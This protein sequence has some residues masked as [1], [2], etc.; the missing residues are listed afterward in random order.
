MPRRKLFDSSSTAPFK[1][2]RSKID[3]AIS[4]PRCFVL[5]VRE[6]VKRPDG[7]PF[8]LNIAVDTLLK[9]EFDLYRASQTPHPL[10]AAAG[11]DVV[12]F[13]HPKLG[14][15][16]NNFKGLDV[17]HAQTNLEIFGS[18]D[19]IWT[20]P[21]GTLH[22]VDYKAT[23]KGDDLAPRL[24]NVAQHHAAYKRQAEIY[25]WLL[26]RCQDQPVSKTAYFVY[27]NG[28]PSKPRFDERLEFR[29]TLIPYEGSHDW[30]EPALERIAETL[31][32]PILPPPA[33]DCDYCA[34]RA[35]LRPIEE[36]LG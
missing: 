12:P 2:S 35:A 23:A 14:D 30:I 5:D 33:Q 20:Q 26:A 1:I 21:D 8:T 36:D 32:T 31:R 13:N 16:R 3:L 11:L 17:V 15:W 6:G 28:I 18:V 4:C 9:R 10:T 25:Q 19:D 34:Y 27:V 7:Y 22:V 24:S 29:T